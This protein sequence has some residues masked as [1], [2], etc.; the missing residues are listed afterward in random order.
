M[1]KESEGYSAGPWAQ[2]HVTNL[3][4]V[5]YRKTGEVLTVKDTDC[6][7]NGPSWKQN[8]LQQKF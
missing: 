1:G 2:N 3:S 8:E 6:G 4:D 5:P 7:W